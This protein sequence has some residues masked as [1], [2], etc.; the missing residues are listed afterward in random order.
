MFSFY[1]FAGPYTKKGYI[2][3]DGVI[4]NG[5][6]QVAT[7]IYNV[8]LLAGLK[9]VERYSHAYKMVYVDGGL[10]ATVASTN[11]ASKVDFKFKNTYKYPIYISAFTNKGKLTIE[12]WS[13]DKAKNG[14]EYKTKSVKIAPKGYKTYLVTYK[15]GKQVSEDFIATTWYP[16]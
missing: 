7:T 15:N 14:N 4:G 11:K 16:K 3:Y 8:E 1:K 9:T 2:Y 6:C 5:V 10:D 13:N 12:F